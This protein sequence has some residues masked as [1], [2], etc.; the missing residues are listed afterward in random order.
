MPRD[1]LVVVG[2]T[3]LAPPSSFRLEPPLE[4]MATAEPP[5]PPPRASARSN[6]FSPVLVVAAFAPRG[7]VNSM[8]DPFRM[9]A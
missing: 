4:E 3:L 2:S 8:P 9:S 5:S 1:D 7:P 6:E